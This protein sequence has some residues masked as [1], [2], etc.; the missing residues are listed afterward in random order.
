MQKRKWIAYAGAVGLAVLAVIGGLYLRSVRTDQRQQIA[1]P[2]PAPWALHSAPVEQRTVD[3]GFP[4]LATIKASSEVLI[5]PQISGTI[6]AMG[7]REGRSFQPGEVLAKIDSS[8]IDDQISA[9]NA[10]FA[11]AV[12]Q[13]DFQKRE[14]DRQEE[15]LE[16]GFTT[17]ENTERVRASYIAARQKAEALRHQ[18]SGLETRR[19][20][21]TIVADSSGLIAD[22]MAEPGDLAAPGKPIYRLTISGNTRI[23]VMVPQS[24]LEKLQVGSKIVLYQGDQQV[25]AR[26][27]R[28]HPTLD[29]LSMG[30]AEADFAF[31]PFSL[32]SGARIPSRVITGEI[33][34]ALTVPITAI[35]WDSGGESGFVVTATG[36]PDRAT[37]RRVPVTVLLKADDAVAISGDVTPGEQV[38]VAQQA[39]LPKLQT[40][41]V[42]IIDD[43]SVQ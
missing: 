11:S 2:A 34:N 12:E 1:A 29:A 42:A 32:P 43:G 20:Y 41:D 8:E 10:E 5:T 21:S 15:L 40:G 37:L 28:I 14:L 4:A 38:I 23:E 24:V 35:A 27:N 33:E 26:L 39:V 7:P 3:S 16:K 31:S 19:S 13:A 18:I 36:D 9:L 25:V 30:S 17:A 22:R 6:L